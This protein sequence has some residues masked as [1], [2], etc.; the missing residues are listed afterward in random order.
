MR[1][2]SNCQI[3]VPDPTSYD[4]ILKIVED[5]AA[6]KFDETGAVP[7]I[8]RSSKAA[9]FTR[10]DDE[11]QGVRRRVYNTEE[12]VEGGSLQTS[13]TVLGRNDKIAILCSQAVV[14]T[15]LVRPQV[16]IALPRFV[17][18]IIRQCPGCTASSGGDRLF[19]QVFQVDERSVGEFRALIFA[20]ERLLPVIAVSVLDGNALTPDLPDWLSDR[21]AGLAHVC[22]LSSKASWDLTEQFGKEWSVYNG[23][24]KLYWPGANCQTSAR[25][26]PFWTYDRLAEHHSTEREAATWLIQELVNLVLEAS[27][28]LSEEPAFEDFERELKRSQIKQQVEIAKS[29]SDFQALAEIYA[30]DNDQLKKENEDLK[31]NIRDLNEKLRTFYS[32][33]QIRSGIIGEI[34]Y[35]SPPSTVVEAVDSA[36]STFNDYLVFP[37]QLDG[38]LIKLNDAAGPPE[39]I[40]R[41]LRILHEYARLLVSGASLGKSVEKWFEDRGVIC[42]NESPTIL[43]SKKEQEK[44][45]W[46]VEGKRITCN[47]HLKPNDGTSPDRCVRI[48]FSPLDGGKVRIGYIGRHL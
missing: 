27:A 48:Y 20:Q 19:R 34:S 44:R 4:G 39:K 22:L 32:S 5:W 35:E 45:T 16:Q 8:R 26:H 7:I 37:D 6:G 30:S 42:S 46:R 43:G 25:R 11:Y 3:I 36:K 40:L 13:L 38:E 23:A 28:Y 9:L 24:V 12:D 2:V 10:N 17:G 18:E 29:G 21:L 15:A 33:D 14:S 1:T 41:Y 47:L 31:E